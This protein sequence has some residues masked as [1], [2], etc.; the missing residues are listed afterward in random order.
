[1]NL[2]YFGC[3]LEILRVFLTSN[4]LKVNVNTALK[5]IL[6]GNT[7]GIIMG[8]DTNKL[9]SLRPLYMGIIGNVAP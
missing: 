3:G 4:T 9:T 8:M 7:Y 5:I 2:N 1:M 6:M